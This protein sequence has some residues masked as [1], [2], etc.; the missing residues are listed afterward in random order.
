MYDDVEEKYIPEY[1]NYESY[2]SGI[3]D[4]VSS[5][6]RFTESTDAF[7][8]EIH[9]EREEEGEQSSYSKYPFIVSVESISE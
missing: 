6:L 7:S 5:S 4:L 9:P 1:S 8:S 2:Q 3:D